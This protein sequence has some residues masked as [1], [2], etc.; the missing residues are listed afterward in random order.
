MTTAGQ[1]TTQ[2]AA[3]AT[4]GARARGRALARAAMWRLAPA[5]ARRR[6]RRATAAAALKRLQ[7]DFEHV[8][9]RHGEQIE[10]LEDLTRELVRT[11]ESLRREIAAHESGEPHGEA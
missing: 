1:T 2:S 7:D 6:A 8:S 4:R 11:A 9:K 10:R 5:Y 3:A